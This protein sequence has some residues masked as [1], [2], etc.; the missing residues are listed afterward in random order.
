MYLYLTAKC[1][2]FNQLL[3]RFCIVSPCAVSKR[4]QRAGL[5]TGST[6]KG[7]NLPMRCHAMREE[8]AMN[9]CSCWTASKLGAAHFARDSIDVVAHTS[10]AK[11]SILLKS[12]R[13][14]RSLKAMPLDASALRASQTKDR[15]DIGAVGLGAMDAAIIP[16]IRQIWHTSARLNG[17]IAA[18]GAP[19][20]GLKASRQRVPT[21]S[22]RSRSYGSQLLSFGVNTL[23]Q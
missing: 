6:Q 5:M 4:P 9:R 2:I 13:G 23:R 15:S 7:L 21:R 19:F 1:L 20:R 10:P 11:R 14:L 8:S 18:F 3:N 12:D 22:C 16:D 17:S